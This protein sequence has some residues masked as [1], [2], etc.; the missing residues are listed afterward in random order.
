MLTLLSPRN[1][2][3]FDAAVVDIEIE[4]VIDEI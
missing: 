3:N 1:E 2:D 4:K